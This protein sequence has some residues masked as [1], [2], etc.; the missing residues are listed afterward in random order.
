MA[1]VPFGFLLGF[2]IAV[3]EKME[4]KPKMFLGGY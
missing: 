3:C 2:F 4:L 1:L